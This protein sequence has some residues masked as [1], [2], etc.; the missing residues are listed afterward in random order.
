MSDEKINS[1]KASDYGMTPY[2]SYYN[3]NKIRVKFNRGFLKQDPGSLF[4]GWIVNFYNVYEIKTLTS[5]I[6]QH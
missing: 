5:S 3:T 2:L 1:F 6:T 4:H